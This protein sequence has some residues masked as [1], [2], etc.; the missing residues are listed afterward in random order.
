MKVT[1]NK[2]LKAVEFAAETPQDRKILRS[3]QRELSGYQHGSLSV[4]NRVCAITIPVKE[5]V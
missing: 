4:H 3:I 5:T 1:L 2:H